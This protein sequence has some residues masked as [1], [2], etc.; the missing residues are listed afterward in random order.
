MVACPLFAPKADIPS[1][2][3]SDKCCQ[4]ATSRHLF[5]HLVGAAKE[6]QRSH[7]AERLL[8]S[9]FSVSCAMRSYPFAIINIR[10]LMI[11]S[12]DL[13]ARSRHCS[14]CW[15]Q[16]LASPRGVA[17]L[18]LPTRA[19]NEQT[20]LQQLARNLK[21][22]VLKE[23]P[24]RGWGFSFPSVTRDLKRMRTDHRLCKL[25]K[26]KHT[27]ATLWLPVTRYWKSKIFFSA[28]VDADQAEARESISRPL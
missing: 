15:C 12:L 23:T 11:G 28:V 27:M 4:W 7:D 26:A 19:R 2:A 21:E 5:D 9:I 22:D 13:F 25:P 3:M 6:G 10:T 1:G 24:A 14:A 20:V 18:H 16:Y 17:M 8:A